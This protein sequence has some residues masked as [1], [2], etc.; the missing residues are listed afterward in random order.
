[1]AVSYMDFTSPSV[2][3]T[4]DLNN[5]Q[6]FKKDN[7]NYINSLSVKELNTLGNASLLDIH[8][9]TGNVV[10]PHTHQNASEL[11]YVIS[12]AAIVS[13]INPFTKELLNFPVMPGQVALVPQGWWHYEMA[14]ADNTHLIAIFD[15]PVPE[16]IPGS[17]LFRLTPANVFA[18]TYCLDEAKVKEAFAPITDTVVIGPPKNCMHQGQVQG[19]TMQQQPSHHNQ[20]YYHQGSPVNRDYEL[21]QQQQQYQQQQQQQLFQQQFQAQEQ[22]QHGAYAADPQRTQAQEQE[23]LRSQQQLREQERQQFIQQQQQLPFLQ[24]QLIGNGWDQF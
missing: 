19:Q 4:Y 8:L 17:D 22:P 9:S 1:M 10:E 21:L 14:T 12:G 3:Y 11:V 7:Q 2:R 20:H 15:A 13:I 16:F 23:Q 24:R 5:N 6:I 18:H